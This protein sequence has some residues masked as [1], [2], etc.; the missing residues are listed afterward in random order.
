MIDFS[1]ESAQGKK[2]VNIFNDNTSGKVNNVTVSVEKKGVDY[3]DESGVGNRPDYTVVFTDSNGSSTN[4]GFYYLDEDNHN[5]TYGTFDDAR[6]KQW[7][8]LAHVVVALNAEPETSFKNDK[9]MLDTLAKQIRDNQDNNKINVFAN[10]GHANSPK[11]YIEVRSW[12]PFAESADTPEKESKLKPSNIDQLI[13]L[14]P[15]DTAT[16][17]SGNSSNN[18]EKGWGV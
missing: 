1:N 8:K 17:S 11:R 14:V 18:E 2:P 7:Q 13:Q 6:K 16:T 15:D 4:R 3:Q 9:V 12:L 5:S 10:F